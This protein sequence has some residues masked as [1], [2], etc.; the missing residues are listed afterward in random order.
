MPLFSSLGAGVPTE[1]KTNNLFA[2]KILKFYLSIIN[3]VQK[4]QKEPGIMPDG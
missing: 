3:F 2:L 4:F 1:K